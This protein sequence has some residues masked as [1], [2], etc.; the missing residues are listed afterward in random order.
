MTAVTPSVRSSPTP[1]P[2]KSAAAAAASLNSWP[3][4]ASIVWSFVGRQNGDQVALDRTTDGGAHWSD[5]LPRGLPNFVGKQS[6]S[7]W[8]GALQAARKMPG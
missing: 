1:T 2:R 6:F 4:T 3:I 5:V 7:Y 8:S